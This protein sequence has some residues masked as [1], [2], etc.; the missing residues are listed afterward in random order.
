MAK[1]RWVSDDFM[2]R[3]DLGPFATHTPSLLGDEQEETQLQQQ[4]GVFQNVQRRGILSEGDTADESTW[5]P[6]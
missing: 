4:G 3:H 6:R 1:Y 2:K 5:A